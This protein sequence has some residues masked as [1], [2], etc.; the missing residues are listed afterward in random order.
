MIQQDF[1]IQ[2]LRKA[3][4][5]KGYKFFENGDFNL[6]IFGVRNSSRTSNTFN[7]FI[8]V[9]YKEKNEW[10]VQVWPATTDA[11][12]H[13]LVRPMN[14]KGTALLVPGQYMQCWQLGKHRGE[15]EALVQIAPMKVYR[16]NDRDIILDLNPETIEQGLFGIN[17]H[18]SNPRMESRQV[19]R[20]SA[21]CQ[22]FQ[23][24]MGYMKFM[25]LVNISAKIWG[26][27]FTYT[28]FDQ[29]DFQL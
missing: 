16:D 15:Y 28:L 27:K 5:D 26:E 17:C 9:V 21:G 4:A 8:G 3:Y 2:L 13:W 7:D 23:N 20:W 6:N 14:V 19:D 12:T 1:T 24:P 18:R 22:V 10:I 25:K 29:T 11:G